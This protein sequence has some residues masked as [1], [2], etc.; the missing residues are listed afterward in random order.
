MSDILVR[1]RTR[2]GLA[3]IPLPPSAL[4]D[5]VAQVHLKL[6]GIIGFELVIYIGND[7]T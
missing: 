6:F 7:F 5:E 4:L 1:V 2:F 3:R